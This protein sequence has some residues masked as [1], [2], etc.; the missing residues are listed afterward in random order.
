MDHLK[1]TCFLGFLLLIISCIAESCKK[2]SSSDDSS[3]ESSE[4]AYPITGSYFYVVVT[5]QL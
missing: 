5:I 4:D 1:C 3:E 2:D